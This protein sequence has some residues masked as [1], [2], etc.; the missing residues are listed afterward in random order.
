MERVAS[1]V[2]TNSVYRNPIWIMKKYDL[3][4]Q[5][6]GKSSFCV[7]SY[8]GCHGNVFRPWI[9]IGTHAVKNRLLFSHASYSFQSN[10]SPRK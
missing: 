3:K 9:A 6:T 7:C 10:A 4:I 2:A 1:R 5:I 8:R